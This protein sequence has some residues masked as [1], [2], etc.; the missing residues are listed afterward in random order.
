MNF[1]IKVFLISIFAL[2]LPVF[3]VSEGIFK[4]YSFAAIGIVL[5]FYYP[6]YVILLGIFSGLDIKK[7]WKFGIIFPAMF[8]VL[9][10]G[11]FR[12][13]EMIFLSF[14]ASYLVLG[15]FVMYLTHITKKFYML[16]NEKK[17]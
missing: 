16:R 1:F 11:V 3:L 17:K 2:L 5:L 8:C 6:V 15:Y 7:R 13:D 12:A 4:N 10:F 14:P 9:F